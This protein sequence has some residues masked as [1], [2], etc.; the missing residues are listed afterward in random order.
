M[1]ADVCRR[2]RISEAAFYKWKAKFGGL[3]VS[4][5]KRLRTLEEE[6]AKLKKLW[7]E[8][9]LHIPVLKGVARELDM[10]AAILGK[11]LALVSDNGTDL[12]SA[13][14]LRVRRQVI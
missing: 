1:T 5:A 12:T 11:L 8:A 7:A 3:Q 14:I 10:I 13:S 6:N 2:H 4:E 9:M